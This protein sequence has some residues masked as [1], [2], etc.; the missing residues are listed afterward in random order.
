MLRNITAA[1]ILLLVLGCSSSKNASGPDNQESTTS[2]TIIQYTE[3]ELAEARE[4]YIRG[5]AAFEMQEYNKALDLLTMAYIKLPDHAGVNFAMADAYMYVADFVNAA[6]YG[7]RAVNLDP[8]NVHYHLKL[9]EI[10]IRDGKNTLAIDALENAR[11]YFPNATEILFLLAATY[12][13]QAR[14]VESNAMYDRILSLAGPDIQIYYQ[15]FRN[16]NMME[17][18]DSSIKTLEIIYKLD[19]SNMSA[20]QT[21]GSLYLENNLPDE[22]LRVYEEA[23]EANPRSPEIKMSLIDF[24]MRKGDLEKGAELLFE[25]VQDPLVNNSVK[26]ELI[27]FLF[28]V[29]S[30]NRDNEG[31]ADQAAAVI[32]YYAEGN[33][34]D[35]GAQALAA[36]FFM[37]TDDTE[38]A[39]LKLQETVRLM[40]ENDAAWRQLLQML[41]TQSEFD[42]LIEISEEAEKWVPEDA[43]IR[44]FVGNAY[45]I[46]KDYEKAILW[47][48]K[49]AEAPSRS[50]FRSIIFGSLGDTYQSA[51]NWD[52]AQK[53]YAESIR[54]NEDNAVALNNYAYYLSVRNERIEDAYE[55]SK[56]SL[57]HEPTNPSFLDTLGWIYFKK[58]N[59]NKAYEYV[60]ASIENG[61]TSAT[62]FEHMGD[63]YEKLGDS[64]NARE[65]WT[66]SF[67]TDPERIYLLKKIETN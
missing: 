14:F 10:Y 6:Y 23:L 45:S 17:D 35:P 8:R 41:Y 11:N 26:A 36:E 67:E 30:Q 61:S 46:T 29:F 20:L 48:K 54:L 13:E 52:E 44:F 12:S 18:L 33:P 47:L 56:R 21:L 25:V 7:S 39:L 55:M 50:N 53:A 59:Y 31:F 42:Q 38:M 24:Y 34:E 40:P 63:I 9:A 32:E 65:W 3:Q 5:I 15:K 1:V 57:E 4:T 60:K 49:A 51:D 62:V 22:A 43:F 66:R 64:E 27:Q 28:A 19:T 37:L 16:Y 2:R 58:G